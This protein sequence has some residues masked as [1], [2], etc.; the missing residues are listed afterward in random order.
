MKVQ[1]GERGYAMAALLV[2]M[3]VM[4]IVL[5]TAM[6]VYQ[7][8]ARREREAELVF[9]GE[10]YARAIA[11]FQRKYGNQLPPDLDVLIDQRF[12]RK[13]YKDPIT[14]GD[15]ALLGAGSPELAQ[16]M[17]TT[18]QQALDAQRGRGA[19]ERGA[20]AGRGSPFG[21]GAQGG[22]QQ[23]QTQSSFGRG[24][25]LGAQGRGTGSRGMG[26]PERTPFSAAGQ[27][28]N[29]QAAGGILA[30]ASKSTQTSLRLY[31]GKTKYNE[32]LFMATAASTQAGAPPGSGGQTP[33]G[34]GGRAGGRGGVG[35]GR[36]AGN[37]TPFGGQ[38]GRGGFS[39]IGGGRGIN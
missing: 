15:F 20:G 19:G 21:A 2:A 38:R 4:A 11:L 10:Q 25:P 26:S 7:T 22:Q 34:R 6:P 39:P 27:L 1:R 31:N 9:R 14:G 16:A 17:S 3:S 30:V 5:S 36:G 23:S 37:P 32:W 29:A 28:S 8:I 18:P 35:P 33:G 12:L 24:T 13:K